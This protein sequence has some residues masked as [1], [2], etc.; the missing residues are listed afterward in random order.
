MATKFASYCI[1]PYSNNNTKLIVLVLYSATMLK[2]PSK[3]AT[4]VYKKYETANPAELANLLHITVIHYP[5]KNTEGLLINIMGHNV[6]GIN[7]NL[8]KEK[9][10]FVLAHEL[11]HYFQRLDKPWLFW[12]SWVLRRKKKF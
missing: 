8:S 4:D 7:S 11:G 12:F 2:P 5:F 3:L 6:I 10:Q 9:Q 1:Y